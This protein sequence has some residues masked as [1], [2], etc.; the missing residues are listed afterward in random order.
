M[1]V[2]VIFRFI[3][4]FQVVAPTPLPIINYVLLLKQE[5][6]HNHML[7]FAYHSFSINITS[8]TSDALPFELI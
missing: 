4:H 6:K 5:G 8:D 3:L 7:F 1:E 2:Q